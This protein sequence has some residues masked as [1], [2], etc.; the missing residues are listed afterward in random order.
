MHYLTPQEV[1]DNKTPIRDTFEDL[2]D[3]PN[4]VVRPEALQWQFLRACYR[5]LI[6]D[7]VTPKFEEV[8]RQ[9]I[10]QYKFEAQTKLQRYYRQT[11]EAADYVFELMHERDM[12]AHG[13]P[14]N[15]Y[16]TVRGYGLLVRRVPEPEGLFDERDLRAYLE[17]VVTEAVA[18]EFRA[19]RTL[20]EIDA[21]PL[22]EWYVPEGPAYRRIVTELKSKAAKRWVISAPPHN[23][24]TYRVLS[25]DVTRLEEG[26]A[27]VETTEY[28]YL[29]WW[30]ELRERYVLP[31]QERSD[32]TYIIEDTEEGW[33][34]ADNIYPPPKTAGLHRKRKRRKS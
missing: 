31:E 5:R 4:L 23:P 24:S 34:V 11:T 22:E 2:M 30:D 33:L 28:R 32:H 14:P 18:A 15:E 25:L 10:A 29:R 27:R 8:S 20:P 16:P 19:Y 17:R 12:G 21:N 6:E 1:T 13:L 26:Q 7:A 9:K 3:A